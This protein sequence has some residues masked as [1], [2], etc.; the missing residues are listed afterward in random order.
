MD[1]PLDDI[2]RTRTNGNGYVQQ[3]WN[4]I[5]LKREILH[6]VRFLCCGSALFGIRDDRRE[7][8]VT[9]KQFEVRILLHVESVT[10]SE[11]VVDGLA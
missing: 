3:E 4:D 1:G 2:F 5:L 11:S 6:L 9:V 7:A 10:G 8:W